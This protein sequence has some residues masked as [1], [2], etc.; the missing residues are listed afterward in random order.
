MSVTD[1]VTSPRIPHRLF[2]MHLTPIESFMLAD[3]QPGYPMTFVIRLQLTGQVDRAALVAALGEALARHPLLQSLLK[4]AKAG[5]PC[6]TLA[7]EQMPALD[8]AAADAPLTCPPGEGFD[9]GREVGLRLWV[10]QGS[11]QATVVLQFHHACCDGTGAYRFIGDMLAAYGARTAEGDDAPTLA[12]MDL[13][14]LRLRKQ[15][16]LGNAALTRRQLRHLAIAEGW[17][18]LTGRP[19]PLMPPQSAKKAGPRRDDFPGF[20]THTFPREEH[21]RLRDAASR[22]GAT[23]NDLLLRDLFLTMERWNREHGDGRRQKNLRIL[24][25]SDLRGGDDFEM[26][27]TNMTSYTFLARRAGDC[28]AADALL[29]GIRNETALIK[30]R[31]AGTAFMDT[32]LVASN[33]RWLMPFVLSR[34]LCMATAVLSNTADPSRRFTGRFPRQGGRIVCG[35]LVLEEISGVSPLRRHTRAAISI[36]QYNRQLT[37]GMR[38]DPH[39][40]ALEDTGALLA[41]YCGRLQESMDSGSPAVSV[42]AA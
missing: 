35:N 42:R 16:T 1:I 28:V 27:A 21:Q 20:L 23:L 40:F 5:R 12:A 11:T 2:P 13:G 6:W 4:E 26:P 30:H 25:P 37:I 22:S 24:M 32:I 38:C 8:W 14:L 36:S 15:R 33:V 34:N 7:P 41:M 3:D 17:K 9:L 18:I 29:D 39:Y 31:R 19:A 10:R